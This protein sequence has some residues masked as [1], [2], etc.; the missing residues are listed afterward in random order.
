LTSPKQP[1]KP[2]HS[3]QP[4]TMHVYHAWQPCMIP[5]N[6]TISCQQTSTSKHDKLYLDGNFDVVVDNNIDF[7]PNLA[8]DR[9]H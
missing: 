2:Q 5:E 1:Q 6:K 3:Q 8:K 9:Q 4:M 7:G